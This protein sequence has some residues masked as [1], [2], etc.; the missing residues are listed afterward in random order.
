MIRNILAIIIV[1]SILIAVMKLQTF[2]SKKDKKIFGLIIPIFIFTV[3]LL[4]AFGG[5]PTKPEI[6]TTQT[7]VTE[8]GEDIGT[9]LDVQTA[10]SLVDKTLTVNSIIYTILLINFGN[11]VMLG[12]YFYYRHQKKTYTELKR[13]KAQELF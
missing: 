7:I 6:E 11:V 2:L 12:I 10:T 1:I 9:P 13:M 3:S 4:L 8:K 5:T